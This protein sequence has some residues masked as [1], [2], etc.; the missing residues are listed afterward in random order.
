MFSAS[1]VVNCLDKNVGKG[2]LWGKM[3]DVVLV[4]LVIKSSKKLERTERSRHK[5][6]ERSGG[7]ARLIDTVYV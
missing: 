1:Q 7:C 6:R 3:T 2:N 5:K 4:E